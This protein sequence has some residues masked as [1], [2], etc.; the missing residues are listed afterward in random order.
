M[1]FPLLI[2]LF[3]LAVYAPASAARSAAADAGTEREVRS[4]TPS[5]FP[6][7][8]FVGLKS[9]KTYCRTGPAFSYPVAVTFLRPGLPVEVVAE[10]TDHWR[11]VRDIEGATCWV[12]QTTLRAPSHVIVIDPTALH[13][14]ADAAAPIRARLQKGVFAE[15]G[16]ERGGWLL[17]TVSGVKGWAPADGL[18]GA[19]N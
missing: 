13:A 9:A 14:R 4:D 10:T 18:W 19:A 8:R 17:L 6:V 12:H 16:R 11:K 5:G 15:V 2:V 1:R 3:G 7:P